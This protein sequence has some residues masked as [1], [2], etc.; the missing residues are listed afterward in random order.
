M[1]TNRL[2][3][4][5]LGL[6]A[7]S[8]TA[9][10]S[11]GTIFGKDT[12]SV[13]TPFVH[14]VNNTAYVITVEWGTQKVGNDLNPG[15][16]VMVPL[17]DALYVNEVNLVAKAYEDGKY[18]GVNTRTLYMPYRGRGYSFGHQAPN[19]LWVIDYI[20]RVRLKN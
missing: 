14:I 7:L 13:S 12:Y 9:C 2:I 1:N 8:L 10:R 3:V 6:L 20:D 18:V 5:L 17:C 11:G 16:S 4:G 19:F 15:G